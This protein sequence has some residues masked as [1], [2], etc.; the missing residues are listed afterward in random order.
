MKDFISGFMCDNK[1][2]NKEK[3]DE[4]RRLF[5]QTIDKIQKE[6]GSSA[7][8]LQRGTNAAVL[9]SIMVSL[10]TVGVENVSDIKQKYD[11]LLKNDA[12][13]DYVTT[14]TTDTERVQGR[15]KMAIN[16]F[17]NELSKSAAIN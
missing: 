12:Y 13:M 3:Q 16:V 11:I 6:L 8:Q 15:I 17:Y 9:D 5:E 4:Y 7:F 14:W 2:L 10:A 1:N